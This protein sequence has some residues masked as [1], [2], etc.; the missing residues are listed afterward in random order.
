MKK[1]LAYCMVVMMVLS[2]TV[3]GTG[4]KA[5]AAT[6]RVSSVKVRNVKGTLKI[7]KGKSFTL[8]T[9]V[10][11]RPNRGAFKKVTYT[12]KNKAIAT[13]T[14]G[15]KVVARKAGSTKIV[16]ASK[17]NVNKKRT[18]PVKVV[19]L[20]SSLALSK[21][22]LTIPETEED[23]QLSVKVNPSGAIKNFKWRTSN[24][25]ICDVDEDGVLYPMEPGVVTITV[26][27]LDGSG[28]KASCKVTVTEDEYADDDDE[29]DDDD[30]DEEDDDE[31]DE[32]E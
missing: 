31:E 4:K 27:A 9:V 18:I 26:M 19:P 10:T 5:V 12:S 6:A 22:E 13:V 2:T 24:E 3:V 11:V 29:D 20:T 17:T 23:V 32:D 8:K 15:G 7:A 28:K 14:A 1:L 30:T 21:T 25:D 16:V